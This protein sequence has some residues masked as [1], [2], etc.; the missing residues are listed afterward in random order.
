MTP[1]RQ[2]RNLS[3]IGFMGTGKS[4]VGRVVAGLLGFEFL[5]TDQEIEGLSG[6]SVSAIFEQHGEPTFREW[7][8]QI[9]GMLEEKSGVVIA[10]G[11]GLPIQEQNLESL[12]RHSLVICLWATPSTI[13]ERVGGHVHRPLLMDANRDEKI[14]TLLSQ[15][16]SHYRKA[17]VLVNTEMRSMTE[18]AQQVLHQFQAVRK[19]P[20][21][22]APDST[23]APTSGHPIPDRIQK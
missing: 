10:T 8:R 15:R 1:P 6:K 17:D 3:L 14:R 21:A 18:V 22:D 13:L 20:P 19:L 5:D 16:E 7:E 2:F 4:S 11:G 12:K 9:C 23:S